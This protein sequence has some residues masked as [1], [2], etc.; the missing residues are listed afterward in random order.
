MSEGGP[1]VLLV[2]DNADNREIYATILDRDDY[3]VLEVGDGPEALRVAR[4]ERPHLILL[5]ISIPV[6]DGWE[7]A[8]RLK[9]DEVTRAIPV[10]ALT[11]HALPEDQQRAR[12]LGCDAYLAKPV[13]P[14][15][16]LEVV[17]RLLAP[18]EG[19]APPSSEVAGS[20]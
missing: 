18:E 3:R 16:V 12:E 14:Q 20:G 4:E 11:A 17:R 7:V 19:G 15:Q 1:V 8:E 10:V 6:I 2:E 5:D 13:R 9:A